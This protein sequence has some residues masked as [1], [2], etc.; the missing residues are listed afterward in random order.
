VYKGKVSAAHVASGDSFAQWYTDVAGVNHTT[1]SKMTLW[2]DGKGNYVNRYGADGEQWNTTA[3]ALFCG[4]TDSPLLDA[5]GKPIPC[6]MKYQYD[7]V[8]NPTGG[9]T[10]CQKM[11]D[12]GYVQVPGSCRSNNGTYTAQYI[13]SKADGNPLFFPVDGDPFT[14]TS[15]LSTATIPPYYDASATWRK[16][17][18]ATGNLIRHNFSF[19]SE[20]RYWFKFDA[21]KSYTLDIVG[22]DDV[23][24]FIGGKLAADLG[25]I[26]LPVSGQIVIDATGN[27]KATIAATYPTSPT[28]MPVK[29]TANLGLQDGN[30]YE[31]AV[32][33]AERQTDSSTF[34][35]TLAGFSLAPSECH[36][37]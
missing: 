30:V 2:S 5:D 33:Q 31:I 11:E 4:M 35:I 13:V 32:F 12:L 17:T 19:T 16:D 28:P 26:H 20:I 14:P 10:D 34:K 7:P 9:K 15:E 3:I 24:V 21:T 1:A 6:T 8:S 25:G 23:W 18:D 37:N 36:P 29:S 27:A 22:D